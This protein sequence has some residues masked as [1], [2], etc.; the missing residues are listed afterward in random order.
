MGADEREVVNTSFQQIKSRI[1]SKDFWMRD[2]NCKECFECG[3]PFTTWRRKHHCRICG[4]IFDA[5]CT[6][7][8]SGQ[9][10]GHTGSLRV[11]NRCIEIINEYHDDSMDMEES[12]D[13]EPISTSLFRAKSQPSKVDEGEARLSS[14]N[15]DLRPLATPMMAIPATRIAGGSSGRRSAVLEI[16]AEEA[17]TNR[18]ASS[19]STK[20]SM[21][22]RPASTPH[23]RRRP[24]HQLSR[25]FRSIQEDKAPFH[26]SPADDRGKGLRLPAFHNDS[27]IDPDLAPYMSDEGTSGDENTS[28]FATMNGESS[29]PG[30]GDTDKSGLGGLLASAKRARSRIGDKTA[31][32]ASIGSRDVD[33]VSLTSHKA[34]TSHRPGRKRNPTDV[35][36]SPGSPLQGLSPPKT[37]ATR[38]TRS[39]SMKGAIAPAVEL[40]NASLQ[41]VRK[42]LRQLLQDSEVPNVRAWEKAL[43]P[44]L[45]QCTDDVNPDIRH[46]DD[47]DIRHYVKIK[48]IPGGRPADT[49]YVS[50]VVFS[51]NLAL[52]SMPRSISHPKI[53][54]ITF[55]IEFQ[56]HQPH[57][58]SLGPII[59]QER[60]YLR[61]MVNRIAA[62]RPQLLLVQRNVSGLAL[63]YLADAKIATVY[64]VKP[65]VL[66]AVSRCAQTDIISS[67]DVLVLKHVQVGRSA[68][69][70]LKT[71]VHR[72][73]PAGKKN[74][75]YI[76]GCPPDL[77]CTVVLRGASTEFLARI[78]RITEFMIYVVYNLKL[79]TCLMRDEF[80]LIP[81]LN[82]ANRPPPPR[83]ARSRGLGLDSASEPPKGHFGV[84]PP[85]GN[86]SETLR[87]VHGD[88]D[89]ETP[90]GV[91]D[92]SSVQKPSAEPGVPSEK[93]LES[94]VNIDNLPEDVPMPTFYGDMVEKH[95]TKILSASPFVK[96]MQPYLLMRAREQER[97][98]AYLKQLRDRDHIDDQIVDE[99]AKPQ[100]FYLITPEMVH[101]TVKNASRKVIEV[102]H[103]VHD[104]EYDKALHNYETQKRQWEAYIAGNINLF[105]PYAHQNIVVLYTVVCTSTAIPCAG[106]DLLALAF[107]NEHDTDEDFEPDC[108]LGQYVEDLCLGADKM[109]SSHGCDKKMFEHHRSYV[110]GEARIT[111]FVE[112]A[113][114]KLRGLQ[115]SILMWSYCKI[116]K[117]ETQVMPMS[118]NTWKYSFGKYLE[119]SFWSSDLRLRASFCPHDL[120]RDHLRY[121]GYKNVAL[122]VHYDPIELLEIIVPRARVTWKV[123]LDL[124]LKNELF[125]KTEDRMNKFMESV[126]ARIAGI[127]VDSVIPE[128]ADVCK[129]EIERLAQRASEDQASLVK[130]LQDKYMN[131][132]YYEVIPLN[133]AVRAMQEKVADWDT[134]FAD[135]DANFFPSEKDI[136]RLAALQLKRI[137]LDRDDSFSSITS[138]EDGT[139]TPMSDT[140]ETG[141]VSRTG[142]LELTPRPTEVCPDKAHDVLTAVVE[143]NSGSAP[144]DSPLQSH[145]DGHQTSTPTHTDGSTPEEGQNRVTSGEGVRHL[146]LAIPSMF[147]Q[148]SSDGRRQP[149]EVSRPVSPMNT[150]TGPSLTPVSGGPTPPELS[151]DASSSRTQSNAAIP[152]ASSI[153]RPTEAFR[154]NKTL[155][156]A[157][158]MARAQSQPGQVRRE[159]SV[160]GTPSLATDESSDKGDSIKSFFAGLG[161]GDERNIP[162]RLG[163]NA[164]KSGKKGSGH[165]F[166][167]RSIPQKRKESRVS[168]LA[169]HFEQ[170][171]REF[172]RERLR[173][174]RMLAAKSRQSRVSPMASSKPI[175]EVY[176]NVHEAVEEREPSDDEANAETP[177]RNSTDLVEM[178]TTTES[179]GTGGPS[180]SSLDK[181]ST[182]ETSVADTESKG[183]PPGT[184]QATSYVEGESNEGDSTLLDEI[185]RGE[186]MESS[187]SLSPTEGS[188]RLDLPKHE[189]SSLMNMLTNFWA[190]RS[191]SGWTA[192]EYPLNAS[193]HVFLDSD[194]IVREDEP[195][196]L[197]AFALSSEDYKAKLRSIQRRD[198][199]AA[200]EQDTGAA[201]LGHRHD[202]ENDEQVEV[203]R[204]LLRPTGTHLKYQFQEGSAKMLC[205]VF[206]AEQFDAVRRKCGVAERIVESLSRCVKWDSKGG[207]SRSV[208][209]KTLDQR[210]VLKSLSPIETQAFLK[211]APAYFQIMSE[212]LFHEVGTPDGE[213]FTLTS[214]AS[215]GDCEDAGLLPDHHQEPSHGRGHQVGRAG[216]G[217]PVLRP[218][219]DADLR[220]QGLDARP[221]D[222]IDGRAGRGAAGREHG[223]IH[224]RIAAVR[225]G[226]LEEAAAGV[227]VERHAVP[228]AAERDGLL[229]DDR[230]RRSAQGAGGGHHRLHPHVHVGQEAGV[231]DQG[232]GLRGRRAQSADGD[233][234]EGVQVAVPGGHGEICPA[235]SKVSVSPRVDALADR[236]SCWHRFVAQQIEKRPLRVDDGG[237]GGVV[238]GATDDG[239]EQAGGEAERRRWFVNV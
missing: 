86:A 209:L 46:G 84:V 7:L 200:D 174:R 201:H 81:S 1:L 89:R 79:E 80:V 110:H 109:C 34:G 180:R 202:F 168:A 15:D 235:G 115:D 99:E 32:I 100:E 97:R 83:D 8:I 186:T 138:M 116:C 31:S 126:K 212:A 228:G 66:E 159:K 173:E 61:N 178:S 237:R 52:K 101:E 141:E 164:L 165:S 6:S 62:L 26:R 98:L 90:E 182:A 48:R 2:E 95:Q 114:C 73:L 191:A 154:R 94:Q 33:D 183:G 230:D 234:P 184:S 206:Y 236:C 9:K 63:E 36:L 43:L 177:G 111:V 120:H 148:E 45:L 170:L 56:R 58:M 51:K 189:R 134:A 10:F 221:Q 160:K 132:K 239:E 142:S 135:F 210:L 185:S 225:A 205:K 151:S 3:D 16:N 125:T 28:I 157:P 88:G 82:D 172:E 219:A 238:G 30:S 104:A 231:V 65:A 76:S 161:K 169:K 57:F 44:I 91:S 131:S 25:S 220:P 193:D 14:Q 40:N 39:A 192:L 42:L 122:R 129:A 93:S 102:L 163:L 195:S 38:M 105:D 155:A 71:Y 144:P 108:T 150:D 23:G 166:I 70:D 233:E 47:I 128:K 13:D 11:C 203:E 149:Y 162:E 217:E 179:I 199:G 4:Q 92:P 78:K 130:D 96:F 211:F 60:E 29:L 54:I 75:I 127:S 69:F 72:D 124:K 147:P 21:S 85:T 103:A 188:L 118:E 222:R 208:F 226:A 112:K 218:D 49:S 223:G 196:T 224:L 207:K 140:E 50:G 121:F 227:G 152:P 67:M 87:H 204:S 145:V 5:K 53:V 181:Q 37:S 167:P 153:P 139:T 136:R 232:P 175:V 107:Y 216:D 64:N 194:V 68:G 27:I 74:Y 19:K 113:P 143:Q 214:V 59:A 190:E 187:Q 213:W 22:G 171:S 158:A 137:F 77:G 106:P 197:I 20:T 176:R 215:D 229:A 17:P 35:L 123:D 146:D 55:A 198:G 133:R 24:R 119:L 41:H 12:D 117:K 156:S 18:P